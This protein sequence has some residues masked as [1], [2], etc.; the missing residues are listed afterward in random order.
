MQTR[1]NPS[2]NRNVFLN[3]IIKAKPRLYIVWWRLRT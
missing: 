3:R 2:R 1:G